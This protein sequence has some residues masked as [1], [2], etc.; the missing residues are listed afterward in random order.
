MYVSRQFS[1]TVGF[2]F[3]TGIT[4][5]EESKSSGLDLLASHILQVNLSGVKMSLEQ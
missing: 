5:F 3:P 1:V 2:V 4:G